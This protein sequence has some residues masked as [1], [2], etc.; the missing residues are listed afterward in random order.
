MRPPPL[1]PP[2]PQERLSLIRRA[3]RAVGWTVV[4]GIGLVMLL[5]GL[6]IL[7]T[8]PL[9]QFAV[10]GYLLEA[11]RR[12]SLPNGLRRALPGV[13][14]ASHV[15]IGVIVSLI[16]LLPV[17]ITADRAFAASLL[18][19][20]TEIERQAIRVAAVLRWLVGIHL[21]IA[22]LKGGKLR[23]L[24]QPWAS[25]WWLI[26]AIFKP[27]VVVERARAALEA[28]H[29]DE[30]LKIWWLGVRGFVGSLLWL[31]PGSFCL[32]AGRNAPLLG[33]LGVVLLLVAIYRLPFLQVH[34]A[35]T[36]RLSA[37]LEG[38][39]VRRLAKNAPL[40]RLLATIFAVALAL[41]LYGFKIEP[42]PA[43][44]WWLAALFFVGLMA[45][46]KVFAGLAV[47]IADRRTEP[48][49]RLLRFPCWLLMLPVG[50]IYIGVLFLTPYVGWNGALGMLLEQHAFLLPAPL[51]PIQ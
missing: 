8:L 2:L 13:A 16:F 12:A 9:L 40:L 32:A 15:G 34:F 24:L 38:R 1:P 19:P 50:L 41:P 21:V 37:F 42:L 17:W 33:V 26:K 49:W 22:W 11:A 31:A 44:L 10:L 18:A 28:V 43:G 29:A 39:E 6:A 45:P 25:A 46:A 48:A 4:R 47:G 36:G 30:F 5:V 7:S 14:E 23:H 27:S 35:R 3:F 20:G 51:G